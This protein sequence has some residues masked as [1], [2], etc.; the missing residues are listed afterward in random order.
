MHEFEEVENLLRSVG[1]GRE[2]LDTVLATVRALR[3]ARERKLLV[4]F[5]GWLYVLSVGAIILYLMVRS[6]IWG[7]E[8]AFDNIFEV[9]KVAVIPIVTL[10]IGYYFAAE[11]AT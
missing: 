5:V 8:D 1:A 4:H 6:S 11:K 3:R 2:E 9:V 7:Q 10:V